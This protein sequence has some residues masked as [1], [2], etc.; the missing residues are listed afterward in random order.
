MDLPQLHAFVAVSECRSFSVAAERLHL[1]QP[2]VSKRITALE[3]SL[4]AAL[5]DRIGHVVALTEAGRTL[6]PRARDILLA[7]EDSRRAIQ[8]LGEAV[9]GRLAF[10]TSHHI[11]LHRLPPVLKDY[12]RRYPE[13]RL[14]IRF[15]DSEVAC[16]MVE[17][18]ALELAVITLPDQPSP[19]LSLRPIWRD[20]LV[21]V[22]APEHPLA[23]QALVTL[24]DLAAHPAVLLGRNTFTWRL[25]E[26]P[27]RARELKLQAAM[28]TNYLETLAMLTAVG[29]GWSVLPAIMVGDLRVLNVPGVA[30]ERR[31]GIVYHEGR[32]LSNAARALIA[33][34]AAQTDTTASA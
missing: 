17:Q 32:S 22:A 8:G 14:D 31:L 16:Q 23:G 11:G 15:E 6:L 3:D 29:L 21:F 28:S 25:I 26:S 4:G 5:F 1:T 19:R 20:A 24:E 12:A 2:A 27:F 18:G 34:L 9:A 30:L 33:L 10:G 13:V 7:A